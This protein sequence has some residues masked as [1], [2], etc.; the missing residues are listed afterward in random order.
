MVTRLKRVALVLA[1]AAFLGLA[2][3]GT[4][5]ADIALVG[6]SSRSLP[7]DLELTSPDTHMMIGRFASCFT[8]DILG[9]ETPEVCEPYFVGRTGPDAN[10]LF[11][12]FWRLST[13]APGEVHL[14]AEVWSDG[15]ASMNRERVTFTATTSGIAFGD[16][17]TC[18]MPG[19]R[20]RAD[21][22]VSFELTYFSQ[23]GSTA[24]VLEQKRTGGKWAAPRLRA[25]AN[26]PVGPPRGFEPYA[27]RTIRLRVKRSDLSH[28]R[29][30]LFYYVQKG[31]RYG[32]QANRMSKFTA[33]STR[34]CLPASGI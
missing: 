26:F 6:P 19:T 7:S 30:R 28:R 4:A 1:A 17:Q 13:A 31:N 10:G 33:F 12:Y 5:A 16:I 23:Q 3:A 22:Q 2:S 32:P 34:P 9:V 21:G 14:D 27:R 8:G 20:P 24:T 25:R 11:H 29:L 18:L 15:S